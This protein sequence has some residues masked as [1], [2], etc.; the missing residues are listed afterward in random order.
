[1]KDI[2]QEKVQKATMILRSKK[3]RQDP[4]LCTSRTV[5]YIQHRSFSQL[6]AIKILI[7]SKLSIN[8]LIK[9]TSIIFNRNMGKWKVRIITKRNRSHNSN[10]KLTLDLISFDKDYF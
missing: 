1:M 10:L 7:S 8:R 5:K 4:K 6:S 2:C 3:D 9:S